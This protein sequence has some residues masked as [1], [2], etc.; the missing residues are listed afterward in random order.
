M[1]PQVKIC[2]ITTTEA[3]K[4]ASAAGASFVG[5]VFHPASQRYL[6]Y[7]QAAALLN[8]KPD[9]L[10][11]VG[12]FV[13][14]DNEQLDAALAQAN[15]DM[16]QLHG[17]E[18]PQDV[19]NIRA[20]TNLPVIKALPVGSTDDLEAIRL[21]ESLCDWLLFDARQGRD[22]DNPGGGGQPFDWELLRDIR[23]ACPW[24]LA[25]GLNA[26]NVKQAQSIV[27]PDMLDVSSGVESVCG[28]KDA[29]LIEEFIQQAR[30]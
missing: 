10:K 6:H 8:H 17:N 9:S 11:A 3:L 12:L 16:I 21:Y 5:L 7:T 28:V 13:D 19:Q 1:P 14:P 15:L 25:G 18:S 26:G 29:R 30:I 4:A 2:G 22:A 27:S 24:M 23:V 20:R